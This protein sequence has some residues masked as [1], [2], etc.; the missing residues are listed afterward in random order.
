MPTILRYFPVLCGGLLAASAMTG[1]D[2]PRTV[3]AGGDEDSA[4]Q[5][6]P[7]DGASGAEGGRNDPGTVATVTVEGVRMDIPARWQPQ[8]VGST[9]TAVQYSIPAADGDPAK[10]ATLTISN[11][12]GGGLMY[13][14]LRWDRQF[15]GDE[16][17]TDSWI[18]LVGDVPVVEFAGRGP[19]DT[20]LPGSTGVREDMAVFGAVPIVN[21]PERVELGEPGEG[22][23]YEFAIDQ[24]AVPMRMS[25]VFIKLTGPAGTVMSAREEWRAM[26]A[27]LRVRDVSSWA[28]P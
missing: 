11:P 12:I 9:F 5:S 25:N 28:T 20:G 21:G 14:V 2:S 8:V 15:R 26:L 18:T 13:N 23:R 22:Q 16:A 19:F 4:A 3:V 7:A 24:D 6:A 1:C 10:A 27:S 17:E